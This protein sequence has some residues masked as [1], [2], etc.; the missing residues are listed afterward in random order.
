M[1]AR[2]FERVTAKARALSTGLVDGQSV[3]TGIEAS[4]AASM[5]RDLL[6]IARDR[7]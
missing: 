4:Y 3:E 5:A 6:A 7:A 1:P 2:T